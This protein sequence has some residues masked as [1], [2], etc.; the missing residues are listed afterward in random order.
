MPHEYRARLAQRDL[1]KLDDVDRTERVVERTQVE[2]DRRPQ[3]RGR[4]GNTCAPRGT[5]AGERELRGGVVDPTLC[6]E[7]RDRCR[8]CEFA[9]PESV[10]A[11]IELRSPDRFEPR[12]VAISAPS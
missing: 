6:L 10:E 11:S 9:A 2:R 3:R 12:V 8:S 5:D 7:I 4:G 1:P